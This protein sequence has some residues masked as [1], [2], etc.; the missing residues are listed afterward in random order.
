VTIVDLTPDYEFIV[1]ACDG[2][3]DVLTNEE[4]IEFVRPRVAQ[5]M[6]P[7]IVRPL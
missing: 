1:L 7:E 5:K 4:V 2:I 6:Q 3:W